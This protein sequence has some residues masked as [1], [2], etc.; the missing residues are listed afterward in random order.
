MKT[1][2][3]L[4]YNISLESD[5]RLNHCLSNTQLFSFTDCF[6]FFFASPVRYIGKADSITISVW[7]HKK[8]HKKQGAGF[9]GCVRLLSNAINRL[10]DTGCKCVCSENRSLLSGAS[11]LL[12][13]TIYPGLLNA[14]I[15]GLYLFV[16][17]LVS[18]YLFNDYLTTYLSGEI[19]IHTPKRPQYFPNASQGMLYT[20]IYVYI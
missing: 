14:V 10:I 13:C 12:Q 5:I 17:F 11:A 19:T 4:Q 8:I 7:N 2:T 3:S 6:F 18:L 1:W 16:Y 15:N 20:Y 9:L